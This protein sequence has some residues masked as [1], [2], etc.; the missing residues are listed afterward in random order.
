[1]R[2]ANPSAVAA[3]SALGNIFNNNKT[4]QPQ[5]Q[6]STRQPVRSSS[7]MNMRR[8][9]LLK[10]SDGTSSKPNGNFT[11]ERRG[12][13]MNKKTTTSSEKRYSISTSKPATSGSNKRTTS[14]PGKRNSL[15]QR[16]GSFTRQM[17]NAQSTF[18]EFGGPQVAGVA[19]TGK[20]TVKMV[21]KYIP[22]RNGLIAVQVPVSDQQP[23]K[24]SGSRSGS[25]R[26]PSSMTAN[27][28][29]NVPRRKV[30]Q[31]SL[32]S[33]NAKHSQQQH[34]AV[35][36]DSINP[37]DSFNRAVDTIDSSVP[38]IETSMREET[39]QELTEEQKLELEEK[40]QNILSEVENGDVYNNGETKSKE[41]LTVTEDIT[42]KS[43]SNSS[44]LQHLLEDN[45]H[46][47]ESIPISQ[48]GTITPIEMAS[49]EVSKKEEISLP[50]VDD[51]LDVKPLSESERVESTEEVIES[52]IVEET[53][54][55]DPIKSTESSDIVAND[56]EKKIESST[57][58]INE[59]EPNELVE[60][61]AETIL[62]VNEKEVTDKAINDMIEI[63]GSI[64]NEMSELKTDMKKEMDEI[65]ETTNGATEDVK[66]ET[67]MREAQEE[68][69]IE[70]DNLVKDN[71][72][73]ND[74]EGNALLK[75]QMDEE[76]RLK[77]SIESYGGNN[78]GGKDITLNNEIVSHIKSTDT[79]ETDSAFHDSKSTME[80]EENKENKAKIS[81]KKLNGSEPKN[82]AQYLRSANP[83]LASGK[84][85]PSSKQKTPTPSPK[86]NTNASAPMKSALK[87]SARP[88]S[89][90]S[91]VYSDANSPADGVYLS[92]TTAENTRM[93]AKMTV[94]EPIDW[95]PEKQNAEKT[96]R[97]SVPVRSASRLKKNTED[98]TNSNRNSRQYQSAAPETTGGVTKKG[99]VSAA[100]V[101]SNANQALTEEKN[102]RQSMLKNRALQMARQVG[103]NPRPTS[104][105]PYST[106]TTTEKSS[107]INPM[108]YPKEPLPKKSS[109]EKLR[110]ND[111][112]L[113]FKKMSLRDSMVDGMYN[114]SE[115][116]TGLR[117]NTASNVNVE[118]TP[119]LSN[120]TSG[121][122]SRFQDSDSEVDLPMNTAQTTPQ[123]KQEEAKSGNG[124][125]LFKKKSNSGP[126]F[127]KPPQPEYEGSSP[128]GSKISRSSSQNGSPN[129]TMNSKFSKSSLRAASMQEPGPSATIKPNIYA[130]IEATEK[131]IYS[132]PENPT[133]KAQASTAALDEE[134]KGLG[135]KLKKLFGRKKH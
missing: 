38:L 46:L 34:T 64:G 99:I 19:H 67:E 30:S 113:G 114:D 74:L 128:S 51:D 71:N 3:A 1:M 39:E 10:R 31:Q 107:D 29:K 61:Q 115:M 87:K 12:S 62:G 43:N 123:I 129:K 83:Y 60:E 15:V 49:E 132:N 120:G 26:R 116:N 13:L 131:R 109:F 130:D 84:L 101:S 52:E 82:M 118:E 134:H 55:I 85:A 24:K 25:L 89:T 88:L 75:Q 66:P 98:K 95:N 70:G 105:V 121:W 2:Q 36:E 90:T 17:K 91:S 77:E 65:P 73:V 44:E 57:E 112:N 48:T 108:L 33:H 81:P 54:G 63:P 122:K 80:N 50:V 47:E 42:S 111:K 119:K 27:S 41:N 32:H 124:F 23:E 21:T 69:V 68:F 8:G 20:S 76:N 79:V 40:K 93:N 45:V 4:Q 97:M 125:S 28:Q 100:A 127:L 16:S 92:L 53:T 6:K 96:K 78:D 59:N 22:G 56:S 18:N 110:N 126:T 37:E 104:T 5:Q 135:K 58:T 133:P 106:G 102:N 86:K 14:L 103:T 35:P 72:E 11:G 9:S 7:M 117:G 94:D